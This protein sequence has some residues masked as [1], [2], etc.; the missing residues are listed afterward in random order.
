[1]TD[2][3]YFS[4]ELFIYVSKILIILSNY[5]FI[6]IARF[7]QMY[8]CVCGKAITAKGFN[9]SREIPNHATSAKWVFPLSDSLDKFQK[10]DRQRLATDWIFQD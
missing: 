7:K 1:M 10:L 2:V 6:L 3:F 8:V 9:V 4:G 5:C